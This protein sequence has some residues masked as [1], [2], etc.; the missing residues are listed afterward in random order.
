MSAGLVSVIPTYRPPRDLATLVELLRHHGPVIVSDDAS[1]CTF[2]PLLAE[3]A[4]LEN[5][6]VVRHERNAGIARGL[7]EGLLAAV[8][9]SSDW[10]LTVD[11]DTVL[12]DGYVTDMLAWLDRY[13]DLKSPIGVVGAGEVIDG[14]ARIRYP[15]TIV[16]GVRTTAEVIQTGSLWQV[17][18]L[19]SIGGFDE[20]FGI[21]AVDAAACV[22]LRAAGYLVAVADGMGLRHSIGSSRSI[23]A[24]GRDIMVTGHSPERRTSMLRNRLR[25][26]PD[27]FRQSPRHAFRSIRRVLVNQ[28]A[29]LVLES[30]RK[31]KA[32]G[33][34]RGLRGSSRDTLEP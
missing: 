17:E 5:V 3:V 15:S 22:R 27:E 11:Q 7:N 12:P 4:E 26:F 8:E 24:F 34:L 25:L 16:E 1:P 30:R 19:R 6:F 33:T 29:G 9:S 14:D 2:D 31:D 18:A 10:L 32:I 20:S 21:D 28:S 23:R 13:H